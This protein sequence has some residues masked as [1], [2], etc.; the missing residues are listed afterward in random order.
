MDSTQRAQLMLYQQQVFAAL[1]QGALP[2]TSGSNSAVQWQSLGFP[3]PVCGDGE[4][5]DAALGPPLN[6]ALLSALAHDRARPVVQRF[7]ARS[8]LALTYQRNQRATETHSPVTALDAIQKRTQ[9]LYTAI[10]AQMAAHNPSGPKPSRLEQI[11]PSS[12]TM[13]QLTALACPT[14]DHT[15]FPA[16][17]VPLLSQ[18][19]TQ[20][21]HTTSAA[22][23]D[24]NPMAKALPR[25]RSPTSLVRTN[26]VVPHSRTSRPNIS[27]KPP[28]MPLLKKAPS[29]EMP[30]APANPVKKRPLSESEQPPNEEPLPPSDFV[31]ARHQ[32]AADKYKQNTGQPPSR[33]GFNPARSLVASGALDDRASNTAPLDTSAAQPTA[34]KRYLGTSGHRGRF[35]PPLQRSGSSDTDSGSYSNQNFGYYNLGN[36]VKPG[37]NQGNA[38]ASK[39][40]GSTRRPVR[41]ERNSATNNNNSNKSTTEPEEPVDERLR[42]IEPRMIEMINNEILDRSTPV[43]WDDIAGLEHAKT[44]IKEVVVWPMLRPDIFTGLRGPPKGLLLF[45]PPGTG[46]TLIGKC[47][48]SQSGATFFSISSSSL[49]SKWVGDGEKMVRALFAV[50]RCNQPAVIFIDEIDSLLTHR[51][52]GEVEASRRIKTEFLIQFDGCGTGS[53]D[54]RILVVGATNRPQEIDEAARR[55]FRKRLYIPLP[56]REGRKAIVKNLLRKQKNCLTDAEI[57]ELCQLTDGYSGS[58]MDG[59]CREAA[60]GPIRS[61]GDI[62]SISADD[63]RP[64]AF[65]DFQVALTQIRASVSDRDLELYTAWNKEYGS[66]G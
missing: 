55:R 47:I 62:C 24:L 38:G 52:D 44:A 43:S 15:A 22:T 11:Q 2:P 25:K 33:R 9:H 10:T 18:L 1:D 42:N 41:S 66:L 61:I 64:M 12:L 51:T 21:A 45:G 26:G 31:T 57:E 59:L 17:L 32:L 29:A 49:T 5:N 19:N 50:A 14:L 13:D 16:D 23:F 39:S 3:R 4:R 35:V 65:A 8:V 30:A 36:P 60:I 28:T 54:D 7:S 46:K 48:A 27:D 56:E 34:K 40:A 63:V 6:V 58:D 37:T 20:D 53:D